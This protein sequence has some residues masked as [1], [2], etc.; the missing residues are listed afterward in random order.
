MIVLLSLLAHAEPGPLDAAYQREYA[1]LQAEITALQGQREALRAERER[2]VGQA[3]R[4]L[5]AASAEVLELTARRSAVEDAL[6]EIERGL[7]TSREG[8][9]RVE[10]TLVRAAASVPDVKLPE[11]TDP[12]TQ[13][14]ALKTALEAVDGALRDGQTAT[15]KPGSWFA[16]DGKRVD[17]QILRYGNVAAIGVGDGP[18]APAGEGRLVRVDGEGT[19]LFEGETKRATPEVEKTWSDQ[20]EAGGIVGAVIIALG[21]AGV[22]LA[23]LRMLSLFG[24]SR[25]RSEAAKLLG[26]LETLG[27]DATLEHARRAPGAAARIIEAMLS[28]TPST[29]EDR[30]N[31][32][33]LKQL[34]RIERFSTAILVIAAVSPLLG[35][36]GTVTGMIGTFEVLTTHGTGDPRMLSGGISEAL[37]TTQLG[38]I[39]AIPMLLVGNLLD[40]AGESL[41]STLESTALGVINRWSSPSTDD[42]DERMA[43]K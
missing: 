34:P 12:E 33:I 27:P 31:E 30:A 8:V 20:L 41:V 22:V 28:G 17:G 26:R 15:V 13:A 2:R 4:D 23:F 24:A 5:T 21:L 3:E 16:E 18:L 35:L 36:L 37:V 14:L 40:R 6:A 39:V 7:E 43:A 11:G 9:D 1:Y 38:L 25:G 10:S 42:G 32:A 19:Y 29:F